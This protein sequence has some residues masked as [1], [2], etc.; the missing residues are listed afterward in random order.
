LKHKFIITYETD[1]LPICP[2][3]IHKELDLAM[4]NIRK[5]FAAEYANLPGLHKLTLEPCE[6]WFP[7][8]QKPLR[9]ER[10][11][12]KLKLKNKKKIKPQAASYKQ[13][14]PSGKQ[15]TLDKIEL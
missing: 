8:E 2:D 9:F 6:G 4:V 15:Q 11:N 14:A 12:L 13:Q 3:A 5:N 10:H 1:G 7:E